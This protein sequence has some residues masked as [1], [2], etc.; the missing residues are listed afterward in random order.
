MNKLMERQVRIMLRGR[1]AVKLAAA[2]DLRSIFAWD[3]SLPKLNFRSWT[4]D[5]V[6]I[7]TT[8]RRISLY[9]ETYHTSW[10]TSN[11]SVPAE[12]RRILD[13][14]ARQCP[15][16]FR[17]CTCHIVT[18]NH[19]KLIH[20]KLLDLFVLGQGEASPVPPPRRCALA[21]GLTTSDKINGTGL[22]R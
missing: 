2:G 20:T 18:A 14:T 12:R 10:D 6:G 9:L 5:Y 3:V 17:L 7:E 15:L 21:A 19:G 22:A 1:R 4:N 8:A 16:W 11:S 13:V